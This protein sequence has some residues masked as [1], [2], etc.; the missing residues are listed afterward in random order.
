MEIQ[1]DLSQTRKPHFEMSVEVERL[2]FLDAAD[3]IRSES[4]IRRQTP[5]GVT[6]RR[7]RNKTPT[8]S[9]PT[10][11]ITNGMAQ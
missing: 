5:P 9:P 8:T 2:R 11:T 6:P 3:T 10:P 4:I 7:P 1:V